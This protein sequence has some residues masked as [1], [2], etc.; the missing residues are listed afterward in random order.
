VAD[1]RRLSAS[2]SCSTSIACDS[3][4][5]LGEGRRVGMEFF[6][7]DERGTNVRRFGIVG[8]SVSVRVRFLYGQSR[9]YTDVMDKGGHGLIY[10][11]VFHFW[12]DAVP[13]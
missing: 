9:G 11:F 5:K 6:S 2:A 12:N 13:L 4:G 1:G 3:E 10:F 7:D 8:P